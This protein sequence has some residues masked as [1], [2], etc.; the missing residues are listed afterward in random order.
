MGYRGLSLGLFRLRCGYILLFAIAGRFPLA[1]KRPIRTGKRKTAVLIP[2]YKEDK[3]IV[4]V[5]QA[6]LEQTY[7]RG[8]YE[9]IVI[10]DSFKAETL[11]ALRPCP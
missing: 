9:V 6:A 4:Q 10:A 5:A 1:K 2:G 8:H 11:D 7:G 3:V